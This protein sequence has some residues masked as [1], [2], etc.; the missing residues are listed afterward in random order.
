MKILIV[1]DSFKGSASNVVVA[2]QIAKGV[3]DVF[4]DAK[5]LAMPLADGGEGSLDAI[6]LS[7]GGNRLKVAS[8]DPLLRA[9]EGY[10]L[11]I[12]EKCFVEL[13]QVSGLQ[14][15]IDNEKDAGQTTTLGT[16]QVFREASRDAKE[17]IFCIGG[18]ATNDAA[19]GIAQA[20]GYHFLDD[21]GREFLPVGRSLLKIDKIIPP[22]QLPEVRIR[23]LCDVKNPFTGPN[24]ATYVYGPQK[25]AGQNELIEIEAGM[26]HLRKK[27]IEWRSIDLNQIEGAGAAGGVGG[28]MVAFFNATLESGIQYFIKSLDLEQEI[29]QADLIFTGEGSID[30][31]TSQGKLISGIT[32]F[33]SKYQKPIIALCGRLDLDLDQ[34]QKIGL[35]AAFSILSRID[36]E[37]LIFQNTPVLIRQTTAQIMQVIKYVQWIQK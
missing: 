27:I 1:P 32:A 29:Q 17:V 15:L 14:L 6:E 18:S 21:H 11:K 31:Q 25:G 37:S 4:P 7:L 19:C 9:R 3:R 13:A 20:M 33:A 5:C 34:M 2:N 22:K 24:G 35:T 30:A 23:V 12:E 26:E 16:G 10:Y 8:V 28:G 36:S